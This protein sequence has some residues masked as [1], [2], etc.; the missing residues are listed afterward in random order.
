M[1]TVS[2]DVGVLLCRV[3]VGGGKES[4]TLGAISTDPTGAPEL[5]G[6]TASFNGALRRMLKG[7]PASI[8]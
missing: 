3:E 5:A 2:F 6:V 7:E 1:T 8:Q 4:S